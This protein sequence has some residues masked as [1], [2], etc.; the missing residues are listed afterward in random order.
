MVMGMNNETIPT[1][2]TPQELL[3]AI[4]PLIGFWPSDS[5]VAVVVRNKLIYVTARLDI[6]A[7]ETP[8]GVR[9][10]AER[11]THGPDGK[12]LAGIGVFLVGYTPAS[13]AEH[14]ERTRVQSAV[15]DMC[16]ELGSLTKEALIVDGDAWWRIDEKLE[17]P[18]HQLPKKGRMSR[19]LTHDSPVMGSREELASS[20]AAPIGEKEDEMLE[21]VIDSLDLIPEEDPPLAGKRIV[22]LMDEWSQ[23]RTLTDAEYLSAVMTVTMGEAR[24]EIWRILTRAKAKQYLPFWTQAMART[25]KGVRTAALCV[26]GIIAWISGEGALMNICLEE[27]EATDPEYPLVDMLSEI[28]F[29]ALPPSYW[30]KMNPS[31]QEQESSCLD[32]NIQSLSE[33]L[34]SV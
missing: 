16:Q 33:T 13:S 10:L 1:I 4:P 8:E 31:L 28:S 7:L 34:V 23:G 6:A 32:P 20:I 9:W 12:K 14:G 27:A 30:E 5:L 2:R 3:D 29:G 24:D 25:P 15:L 11:L 18:G 26:T 22:S 19:I 21:A 17:G